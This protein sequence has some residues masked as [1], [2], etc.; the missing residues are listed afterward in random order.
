[1]LV[2]TQEDGVVSL[3]DETVDSTVRAIVIN[4]ITFIR[5]VEARHRAEDAHAEGYALGAEDGQAEA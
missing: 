5:E 1:M 3:V 4:G 2:S